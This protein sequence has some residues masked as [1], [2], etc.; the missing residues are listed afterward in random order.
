MKSYVFSRIACF[1]HADVAAIMDEHERLMY[2]AAAEPMKAFFGEIER[3]W[4]KEVLGKIVETPIGTKNLIASEFRIRTEIYNAKSLKPLVALLDKAEAAVP[5]GSLEARR[6][7]LVRREYAD[8]PVRAAQSFAV[9]LSAATEKARRATNPPKSV[10]VG[11]K[12]TTITVGDDEADKPFKSVKFAAD[13]KPGKWYRI[14]YFVKG[15]NIVPNAKRGGANAVVWKSEVADKGTVYPATGFDGTFDW[16]HQSG[17]FRIPKHMT[18]D[19]KPE[20]DVRLIHATGT[21][22]FDGLVVEEIDKH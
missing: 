1:G 17:E 16:V 22:H 15:E 18:E 9:G 20:V 11:F 14:S 13:L 21:A 2:G 10:V 19:F 12:P 6:I 4:L 8:A 5:A 3:K 7:A